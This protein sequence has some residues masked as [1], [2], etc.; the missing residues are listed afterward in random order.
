MQHLDM[1]HDLPEEKRTRISAQQPHMPDEPASLKP[2]WRLPIFHRHAQRKSGTIDLAV[3]EQPSAY[4]LHMVFGYVNLQHELGMAR[5]GCV[6][7]EVNLGNAARSH[8]APS[9]AQRV[10]AWSIAWQVIMSGQFR[11]T[12]GARIGW[13]RSVGQPASRHRPDTQC[14]YI[15]KTTSSISAH[16]PSCQGWGSSPGWFI[17]SSHDLRSCCAMSWG[18]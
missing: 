13:R 18:D 16:W 6:S 15:R 8:S 2:V 9:A 14:D 17:R 3:A 7:M 12:C 10:R 11:A 5:S 1:A 4:S